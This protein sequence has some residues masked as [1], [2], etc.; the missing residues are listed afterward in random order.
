MKTW[1]RENAGSLGDERGFTLPEL[2]TTIAIL[3]ILLAIA[4]SMW[5][6]VIESRRVDSAAN[7]LA[8][9]MRLANTRA[10]NQLTDW[11]VIYQVGDP[12]YTLV[13]L[14]ETCPPQDEGGCTDPCAIEAISRELPER[15]EIVESSNG[16]DP[17]GQ[18]RFS[19]RNA[20][21]GESC[22]SDLADLSSSINQPGSTST[23]EF[24]SDG[25]SY[26]YSGPT[27]GLKV[28]SEANPSRCY[29]FTILA[30]TSRV[31]YAKKD[32]CS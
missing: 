7:Q 28:G 24:N 18:A 31:E 20:L 16:A 9:D 22:G 15:T 25:G 10:T 30:A 23:I 14:S 17:N 5:N 6:S 12:S 21:K 11:R 29:K 27:S 13:R 2:L 4:M 3:G 26:A 19:L 8:S 32:G 1:R